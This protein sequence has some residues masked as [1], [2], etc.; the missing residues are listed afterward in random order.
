MQSLN[1]LFTLF[2]KSRP[3]EPLFTCAKYGFEWSMDDGVI[4][5]PEG[6]LSRSRAALLHCVLPAI[7]L[8][9]CDGQPGD[10]S[11][12]W[13]ENLE[14]AVRKY[15]RALLVLSGDPEWVARTI[16]LL[17]ARVPTHMLGRVITH[18]Q[19][20]DFLPYG[21]KKTRW[22]DVARK[23]ALPAANKV[24]TKIAAAYG[25]FN[26]PLSK[27]TF[28]AIL[29]RYL[30]S[31]DAIVPYMEP[32]SQYFS[33][34]YR[35]LEDEVF[36][37]CG[38]YVGDTLEQYIKIKQGHSFK[39]YIIFEP[40]E[41][42]YDLLVKYISSLPE[43]TRQKICSYPYAV[44]KEYEILNFSG[45]EGSDAYIDENGHQKITCVAMD[46]ILSDK[47]PTFIKMDLQGHEAYALYGAK[48]II[49]KFN[50]VLAISVY[51][52]VHDLWELPLLMQHFYP[53]YSFFLRAYKHEEEYIC[54][55]VPSDRI[56]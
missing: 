40:D 7:P 56:V 49:K 16:P 9:I 22:W 6:Y 44:G 38:G 41:S 20:G 3:A 48:N 24:K 15:P 31:S 18:R 45:G 51:H 26:D 12:R 19:L 27:A 50:P 52:D 25:L 30:F 2:E 14:N 46:E 43:T 36:I 39:E 8:C 32:S 55:A 33:N 37:D 17:A 35:H 10:N 47:S 29:R 34:V 42:N 5:Y 4:F 53:E 11:P 21:T 28:L 23:S 54:Y 13:A 1:Q